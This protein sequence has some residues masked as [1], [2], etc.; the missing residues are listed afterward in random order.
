MAAVTTKEN[1]T[2]GSDMYQNQLEAAQR[3]LDEANQDQKNSLRRRSTD[4]KTASDVGKMV[5]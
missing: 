1:N 5:K 2:E 3:I 4:K